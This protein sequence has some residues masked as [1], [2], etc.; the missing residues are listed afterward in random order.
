MWDHFSV[1]DR[2]SGAGICAEDSLLLHHI[3]DTLVVFVCNTIYAIK[4]NPISLSAKIH[5]SFQP[6]TFT[7]KR[8]HP[9]LRSTLFSSLR[10]VGVLEV[11][12]ISQKSLCNAFDTLKE[13]K[14]GS[15]WRFWLAWLESTS[16]HYDESKPVNGDEGV[17]ILLWIF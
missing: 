16:F 14:F 9:L 2:L 17:Y 6:W 15:P 4:Q 7:D 12:A 1:I 13:S 3:Y 11:K 10:E 5:F 8:L